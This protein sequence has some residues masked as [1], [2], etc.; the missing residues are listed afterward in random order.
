LIIDNYNEN[1][2]IYIFDICEKAAKN[3]CRFMIDI[4]KKVRTFATA[5]TSRQ[6]VCPGGRTSVGRSLTATGEA[7]KGTHFVGIKSERLPFA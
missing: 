6:F 5:Y 4:S 3:N 7:E 1:E 2:K